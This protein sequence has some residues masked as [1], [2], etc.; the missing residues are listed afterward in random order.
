MN[1]RADPPMNPPTERTLQRTPE[2]TPINPNE[3][4]PALSQSSIVAQ[5]PKKYMIKFSQQPVTK[6]Q[7]IIFPAHDLNLEGYKIKSTLAY[8][9]FSTLSL[10]AR[11]N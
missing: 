6:Q 1:P 4:C 3:P 9:I 11:H 2:I 7:K 8:K 5:Y 10:V